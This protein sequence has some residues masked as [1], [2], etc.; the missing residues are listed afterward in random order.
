MFFYRII[1]IDDNTSLF[2]IWIYKEGFALTFI[3]TFLFTLRT[4]RHLPL[5]KPSSTYASNSNSKIVFPLTF[6]LNHTL[7]V[8]FTVSFIFGGAQNCFVRGQIGDFAEKRAAAIG[9]RV[10]TD[11]C[12]FFCHEWRV[13]LYS[14]CTG[15]C[16][17]PGGRRFCGRGA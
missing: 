2:S 11:G 10:G 14:A 7:I 15:G 6:L 12:G 3:I 9:T 8:T 13:R 1:M 16:V 17:L 5:Q 4:H